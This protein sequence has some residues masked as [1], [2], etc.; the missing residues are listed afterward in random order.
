MSAVGGFVGPEGVQSDEHGH[1]HHGDV[2]VL[3]LGLVV[4]RTLGPDD[5]RVHLAHAWQRV[6]HKV[7][8]RDKGGDDAVAKGQAEGGVR[9]HHPDKRHALL[10]GLGLQ[11]YAAC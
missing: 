2:P 9:Q 1:Q 6:G 7:R 8:R 3:L 11:R 10:G 4:V 5:A